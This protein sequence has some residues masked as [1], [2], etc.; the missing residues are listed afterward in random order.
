MKEHQNLYR[1]LHREPRRERRKWSFDCSCWVSSEWS[2][3]AALQ[4]RCDGS[5][6]KGDCRREAELAVPLHTMDHIRLGT[7]TILIL[8]VSYN[9]KELLIIISSN[10]I[11]ISEMSYI[12]VYE[13]KFVKFR[14]FYLHD[15]GIS[16][17]SHRTNLFEILF[18]SSEI[19]LFFK[20]TFH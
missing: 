8:Q 9:W 15:I 17:N 19:I 12:D 4:M 11:R 13:W 10:C 3:R 14:K 5:A 6:D 16:D 7:P 2:C 1:I 20:I 18:Q